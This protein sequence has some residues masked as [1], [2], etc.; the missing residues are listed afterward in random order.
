MANHETGILAK[1]G[2]P[3]KNR[4]ESDPFTLAEA[5]ID[6]HLADRCRKLSRLTV[7]EFEAH[8]TET[9]ERIMNRGR[10]VEAVN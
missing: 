2:R 7:V 3:K 5:G 10:R 4:S 9:R 6:K 1:V 8:I